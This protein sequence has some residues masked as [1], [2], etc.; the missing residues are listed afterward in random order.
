MITIIAT[1]E[2]IEQAHKLLPSVDVLFFGEERFGL[3]LPHHFSREEQRQLVQLAHSQGKK[4]MVA[5]N[6]IMHP[7]KMK[8]VPEYLA[9][10][11]EI[12]VDVISLGDPGIVYIMRKQPELALPFVYD[13]ETL[14]TSARQMNFWAKKGAIGAVLAREVP[15]EEMKIMSQELVIP[16]E[17]LVYGATCIHQS[18]RPLLKNYYNFTQQNESVAK[19]RGLF[20]AEP[21]KAETHYS[22]FED[23]H[24]TH[25]FADKD[26]QLMNELT[27]L[28]EYQFTTWKL[29]GI[30]CPGDDFVAIA[31][32]FDQARKAIE[33]NHFTEALCAQLNATIEQHHPANRELTTGF[34]YMDPDAIK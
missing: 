2:S 19:E 14:V 22:I 26:I 10:L 28:V 18:L 29:D 6:G 7:E 3:R 12:E 33:A 25:I 15:F 1:V 30:F 20:L 13:G 31:E 9:F 4:A 16:A 34:Y 8:E 27:D 23:S 21:K 11:K 17:V 24:G 5:V 32:C